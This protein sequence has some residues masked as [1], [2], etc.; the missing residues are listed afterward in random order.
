MTHDL[1]EAFELRNLVKKT[2]KVFAF[3]LQLYRLSNAQGGARN[4]SS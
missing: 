1:S 3:D 4:S 2:G